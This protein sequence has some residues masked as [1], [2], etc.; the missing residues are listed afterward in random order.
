MK[1]FGQ[2]IVLILWAIIGVAVVNEVQDWRKERLERTRKGNWVA[3]LAVNGQI[4]RMR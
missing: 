4:V 1:T 3:W 2:A